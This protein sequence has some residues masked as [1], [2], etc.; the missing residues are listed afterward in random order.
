MKFQIEKIIIWPKNSNFSYREVNLHLGKVNVITGKSRTGKTAIIPIIDYCLGASSCS[1][2]IEVIR[3]NAAWYG[4]IIC[5]ETEKILLARKVPDRNK[6]SYEFFVRCGF[7]IMI[8]HEIKE[9]N[10]NEAGVLQLLDTIA[11]TPYVGR[12][13]QTGFNQRLSFRDL[14][15]LIFQSQ[16]IVANQNILFYKTHKTEHREKLRNWFPFI[17]GAETVDSIINKQQLKKWES[18][19]KRKEKELANAKN[20]SAEWLQNLVGQL[21]KIK[22]YIGENFEIPNSDNIDALLTLSKEI[23]SKRIDWPSPSAVGLE[24]ADDEI[25]SLE[26]KEEDIA[27]AI[28]Q[29]RKRMNEIKKMSESFS[30][31]QTTTQQK[32]ERLQLVVWLKQHSSVA[33]NCPICGE[34]MHSAANSEIEKICAALSRYEKVT[35]Q[36]KNLPAA[37]N[38][39]LELLRNDLAD[40]IE[41]QKK[42]KCRFDF[43]QA[44]KEENKQYLQK[45][46]DLFLLLGQLKSTVELIDRISTDSDLNSEI[47]KLQEDIEK[48]KQLISKLNSAA[49]LNRALHIIAEKTLTHL[50]TLDVDEIY[51]TV[52]PRFSLEELGIEIQG[53][54]GVWHMLGEVGSASNWLSFHIAFT[55]ALQEFF[56]E[57]NNPLSSVPS[58]T[59]Y[60]QPSQ[61]YFPNHNIDNDD[62]P[63]FENEDIRAARCIFETLA[64]SIKKSNGAWQAIVLDH[65]GEDVFGNI[66]GVELV[67]EWRNGQALIPAEWYQCDK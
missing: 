47:E 39:E 42:I 52:A 67:E 63:L 24:N 12:E 29:T 9:S 23:L 22:E 15:H 45:R 21:H 5:T 7:E 50:K 28:A 49:L 46:N 51:K 18:E 56:A 62:A 31:Y 41:K 61:V 32:I 64:N 16:D 33:A 43:I 44:Q 2:P 53:S 37:L 38:R 34:N 60:D 26:K 36:T 48:T 40:F 54:D 13:E 57:K 20:V 35:S 8:P 59:V 66:D 30:G 11:G 55:C 1:V 19:L 6:V 14:T 58:F 65:A 27:T 4:I 3:N 25:R 10:Q 17:L